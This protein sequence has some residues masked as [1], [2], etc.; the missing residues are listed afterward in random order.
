MM[1][2][3]KVKG[4]VDRMP[5]PKIETEPS[6][7]RPCVTDSEILKDLAHFIKPTQD[8]QTVMIPI[9][10]ELSEFLKDEEKYDV[11][12]LFPNLNEN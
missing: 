11:N 5:T 8:T 3:N 6:I 7:E 4:D 10:F 12:H 9:E 2:R 1:E